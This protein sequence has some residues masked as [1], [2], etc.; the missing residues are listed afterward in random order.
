ML[1]DAW[2]LATHPGWSW[3]DLQRAP[4]DVISLVRQIDTAR[5]EAAELRASL[6]A[7]DRDRRR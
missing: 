1:S 6:A 2:F 4:E 7:A 5:A 3:D